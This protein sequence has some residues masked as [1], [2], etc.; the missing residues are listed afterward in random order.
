[1]R[2]KES[3]QEYDISNLTD[4]VGYVNHPKSIDYLMA[5]DLLILWLPPGM[6]GGMVTGKIFEYLASGK[7]ILAMLPEGEAKKLILKLKRGVVVPPNDVDHIASVIYRSFILWKRGDLKLSVPRW[8]EL[9][10]FERR[11]QTRELA[12]IFNRS[13]QSKRIDN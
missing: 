11:D 10:R 8:K 6:K 5:S 2:L 9:N 3:L 12:V 1:M 13:I 7:P 4:V